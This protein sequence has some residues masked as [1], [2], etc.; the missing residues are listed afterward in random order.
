M[1]Q[2]LEELLCL[3]RPPLPSPGLPPEPPLVMALLA[4]PWLAR[5]LVLLAVLWLATLLYQQHQ[6]A[7]S[8]PLPRW[9]SPLAR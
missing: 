4:L 7:S 1:S 6:V 3:L 5:W 2:H 8:A 9:T